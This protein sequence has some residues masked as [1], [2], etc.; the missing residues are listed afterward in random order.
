MKPRKSAREGWPK[1]R[2]IRLSRDDLRQEARNDDQ[3]ATFRCPYC[4]YHIRIGCLSV[5][6]GHTAPLSVALAEQISLRLGTLALVQCAVENDEAAALKPWFRV[7][8]AVRALRMAEQ[9]ADHRQRQPG[10]SGY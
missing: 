9:S 6:R 8:T 1:S 4:S 10:R 3:K 2:L 7:E 5:N